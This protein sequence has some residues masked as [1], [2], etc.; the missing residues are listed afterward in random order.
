MSR[1]HSLLRW[2]SLPLL[3]APLSVAAGAGCG[4][5]NGSSADASTEDAKRA[6]ESDARGRSSS[7]SAASRKEDAGGGASSTGSRT[8]GS[9]STTGSGGSHSGTGSGTSSTSS[10]HTPPPTK[11]GSSPNQWY[12]ELNPAEPGLAGLPAPSAAYPAPGSANIWDTDLFQDSNVA[13]GVPSGAS[14]VVQAI[15]A[16]GHY[17][18]CYVECGAQQTGFP[19]AAS[20]ASAD[21]TNGSN[22]ATTQMQ[23]YANEHWFNIRGF[24]H[25]SSSAPTTFPSDGLST[26]AADAMAAADIAAGLAKRFAWCKLEG[27]DAVEPDDLDGYTN[28]SQTGAAGGGWGLTQAQAAGFERWIAYQTHADGLAVF[29]KNDSANASVNEPMY[30]G[31]ITEE[32]NY[33]DDPCSGSG[34]DW[35]AFLAA[36]K[37]VLNAEYTS[38]GETT[39]KF[40]QADETAGITGALFDVAL[41][42]K[43]YQPCQP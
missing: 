12:W 7:T 19:D 3:L 42:G 38:D 13:G 18:I 33:Y 30:D 36:G 5:S 21:Y 16:A 22:A 11:N 24:L 27:H 1:A 32:C 35:D 31:V 43:T 10:A 15:H 29:Q 6:G 2:V 23:G 40:C 20:F 25:W 34:G 17:S 39:A 28:A 9:T 4:S 8:G 37:P 14:P 26:S 41:D